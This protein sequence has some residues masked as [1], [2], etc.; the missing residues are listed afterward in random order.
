PVPE[1]HWQ[2]T[3]SIQMIRDIFEDRMV[4]M[5]LEGLERGMKDLVR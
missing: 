4:P 1:R 2:Y 3:Q 5:T